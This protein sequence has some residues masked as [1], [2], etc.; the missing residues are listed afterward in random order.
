MPFI[1]IQSNLSLNEAEKNN[2]LRT[3]SAAVAELLEK[4]ED[5]VMTAWTMSKMTM[6]GTDS[7]TA[8]VELR[9]IRL[10][11]EQLE[12]LSKE[13]TERLNLATSIITDRI[14]INFIDVA[15]EKWASNGKTFT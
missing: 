1:H 13:L 12:T 5:V 7:P 8:L 15:P 3:L 11:E 14:F 2:C 9:A 6:G 4:K 10:P